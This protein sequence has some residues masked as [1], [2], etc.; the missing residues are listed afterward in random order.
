MTLFEQAQLCSISYRLEKETE[1][2]FCRRLSGHE[3]LY[4]HEV[5]CLAEDD[6]EGFIAVHNATK[7]AIIVFRGTESLTDILTDLRGWPVTNIRSAGKVHGGVQGSL[8]Q[9]WPAIRGV[10]KDTGARSSSIFGHSLGGMLAVLCASWL[11]VEVPELH[12]TSVTTFGSPACGDPVFCADLSTRLPFLIEHVINC[13]DMVARLWTP[14]F[15]GYRRCGRVTYI[16]HKKRIIPDPSFF[17]K[18]LDWCG[19]CWGNK[20]VSLGMENHSRLHY[21]ELMGELKL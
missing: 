11:S 6:L 1:Y 14:Y 3:L 5:Y 12:L 7:H 20:R 19:W 9:A 16:D 18:V 8:D 2:Q 17:C 13:V 15:M 10:L 4:N 21:A